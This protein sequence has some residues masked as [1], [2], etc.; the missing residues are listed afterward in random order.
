M[1]KLKKTIFGI[2][3]SI[4]LLMGILHTFQEKLIFLP[5]EIQTDYQYRFDFD[6]EEVN[7]KTADQQTINALHIKAANPKGIILFFHGNKGNLIRW[8][9]ITSYFTQ[10]NYDV[11]VID[12]RGYGKSTGAFNETQMY[13][14]A[15]L[16][17]NYVKSKFDE[18]QI[19]V[20]GRSLGTTFATKVGSENNPKHI[21]LEAPFFSLHNAANHK[22][23]IVPKF[24]LNFKFNTNELISKLS[25]PTTIFHGTNDRV[26]PFKGSEALF[27]LLT[28]TEKELVL[29]E[30]GTHH[31]VRDFDLYT[32]AL[33]S[34]LN[35]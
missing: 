24:L 9:E 1:N 27:E 3:F 23:K 4:V 14:D 2:A 12:Y 7:L 5:E 8:G 18:D 10:Y 29:L 31:N 35:H 25:S 20:Y 17:Y 19:V 16:S 15:L 34:I 6:F 26:T 32:N 11:F 33:K 28:M 30:N 22:Y 21:I 13:K